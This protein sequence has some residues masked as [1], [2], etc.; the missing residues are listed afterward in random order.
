MIHF[1]PDSF[2]TASAAPF[3]QAVARLASI[4]T[5]LSAAEQVAGIVSGDEP[6]PTVTTDWPPASEALRRCFER[7]SDE[8]TGAA[9]AG[10]EMLAAGQAHPESAARL[11][12]TL[13]TELA[14]LDRLLSL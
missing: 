5:A 1:L 14:S 4:R 6:G 10:L 2:E 11:A 8:A 13:R 12:L 9:A 3:G 7:R